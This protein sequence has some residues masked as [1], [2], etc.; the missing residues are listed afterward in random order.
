[1]TIKLL[2]VTIKH[3]IVFMHLDVWDLLFLFNYLH[4]FSLLGVCFGFVWSGLVFSFS[5][6]LSCSSPHPKA[7][8]TKAWRKD[9][10]SPWNL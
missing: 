7:D 2:N 6:S 3:R 5:F 9:V 8:S 10:P 4:Y 1:M